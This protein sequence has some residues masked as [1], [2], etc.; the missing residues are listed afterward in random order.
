[1]K[2]ERLV[3][4]LFTIQRRR[5]STAAELAAELE[6]SER[7]IYRDIAALQ[8]A[9]VPLWSEPGRH[10]GVQLVEGWRTQLDGLTARE[11]GAMFAAEVPQA[12]A[13]LGLGT[14]MSAARAK[15]LSTM[16][17]EL[18]EHAR[19]I[20]ERFH[21]DAPGWFHRAEDATHLIGVAQ[22]V[23]EQ[24]RLR[25]H[26]SKDDA[27]LERVVDPLGL[28]MKAAVW[29]LVA[30]VGD[31]I[32]T[33]RVSRIAAIQ[34]D[35]ARFDRPA[36]F[37]LPTWWAKSSARFERSLSRVRVRLRLGP[38]GIRRLRYVTDAQAAAE[39]VRNASEP[40]SEGWREVELEVESEQVA[41]SE[42]AGLGPAVEVLEPRSLR[43]ALAQHGR[44]IAARNAVD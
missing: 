34:D 9:G 22:A 14:A 13:E 4:L 30:R 18:R 27:L 21:L 29:Y 10:G 23:W 40:D 17:A 12:L 5:R 11:A 8:A 16:P 20:A 26:Y 41:V 35:A 38:S 43:A 2:A 1:M 3:A 44:A 6:V 19:Q 36:D 33:Y 39:A 24:R 37:D 42:L 15:V 32:R 28:V 31:D 25:M 7:T